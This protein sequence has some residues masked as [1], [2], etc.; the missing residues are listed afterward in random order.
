[1]KRVPGYVEI[2]DFEFEECMISEPNGLVLHGFFI[3]LS[4]LSRGRKIWGNPVPGD[5]GFGVG[6]GTGRQKI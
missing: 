2:Q 1:M 6:L 4:V 3:L 5:G